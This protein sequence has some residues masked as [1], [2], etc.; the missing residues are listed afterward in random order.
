[1]DWMDWMDQAN[2]TD[3]VGDVTGAEEP[4]AGLG[5]G[6]WMSMDSKDQL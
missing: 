4:R 3:E 5:K 1:M 2:K 6:E